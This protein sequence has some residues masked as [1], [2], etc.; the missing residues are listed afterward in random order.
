VTAE[1][2]VIKAKVGY[3]IV[4][5]ETMPSPFREIATLPTAL[6]QLSET[7]LLRGRDG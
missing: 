6:M 4:V 1:Q 3:G 5:F 7:R 2:K